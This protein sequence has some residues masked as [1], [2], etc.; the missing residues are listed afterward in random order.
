MIVQL[1]IAGEVCS[2]WVYFNATPRTTC[3]YLT[4]HF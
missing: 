1:I 3:I 4:L 2:H